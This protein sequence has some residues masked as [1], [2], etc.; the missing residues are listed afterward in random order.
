MKPI[1]TTTKSL[2]I[3]PQL[4]LKHNLKQLAGWRRKDAAREM[5]VLHPF[6]YLDLGIEFHPSFHTVVDADNKEVWRVPLYQDREFPIHASY[7]IEHL[8]DLIKQGKE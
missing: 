7:V 5:R 4:D 8:D 1:L 2:S 6:E 3:M